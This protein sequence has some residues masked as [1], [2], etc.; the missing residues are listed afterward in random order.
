MSAWKS[1]TR[2]AHVIASHSITMG[3]E[4]NILVGAGNTGWRDLTSDITIRGR[5]TDPTWAQIGSSPFWGYQFDVG[6]KVWSNFHINHDYVPGAP[7]FLHIHWLSGG[8]DTTNTT[9]WKLDYMIAKG[10]QQGTD[11]DFPVAA[12][13]TVYLEQ[14]STGQ[15]RHM[16]SETSVSIELDRAEVDSLIMVSYERV[17][18]GATDNTDGIFLLTSDC[19]YQAARWATPNRLP[20]F[21]A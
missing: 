7:I 12:Y 15:Y 8:S 17:T 19:H 1:I 9:K 16:V 3:K 4:A 5:V 13:E 10:H 2:L 6:D 21:Y 11:S 18:N 14:A 20:D